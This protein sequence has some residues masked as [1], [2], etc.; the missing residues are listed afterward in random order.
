VSSCFY[1]SCVYFIAFQTNTDVP[2]PAW[3]PSSPHIPGIRSPMWQYSNIIN[4]SVAQ[5]DTNSTSSVAPSTDT[6]SNGS[7]TPPNVNS[8]DHSQLPNSSNSTDQ[9]FIFP[10]GNSIPLSP[11]LLNFGASTFFNHSNNIPMTPTLLTPAVSFSESY[12]RPSHL[13]SPFTLT[14]HSGLHGN[15]PR[16]PTLPPPSPQAIVTNSFPLAT[17]THPNLTTNAT[18]MGSPFHKGG[19]FLDEITKIGSISPFIVSPSLS[20]N[21]K[22]NGTT[23]FFPTHITAQGEAKF[24]SLG[25][26]HDHRL[27]GS[28]DGNGSPLVKKEV[29]SPQQQPCY[30]EETT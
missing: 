26:L 17:I 22:P 14:P 2:L 24:T 11:G 29:T 20:P 3:P 5:V 23:I 9:K 8:G 10:P 25:D 1:C 4:N 28:P 6:L 15:L 18:L 27:N 13:Y 12:I 19:S 30:I 16:T 7:A 21:R